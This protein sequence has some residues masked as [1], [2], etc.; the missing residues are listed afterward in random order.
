MT[1]RKIDTFVMVIADQNGGKSNQ[2]R[3][4]FEEPELTAF[5]G[6]Y[7]T[8]RNIT[9]KYYVHPDM[10]LFLR[11]SSWHERQ[12]TYTVVK[13]DLENGYV[14]LRR[15]YKVIVPAQVTKTAKLM[16]GEDLFI[17]I[18]QDFEVRRAFAVWL[19]PDRTGQTPFALS[20]AFASFL[21]GCRHASA[22]A[23]DSLAL[24]PSAA[25]KTNT[26]NARLLAD[27]LFRV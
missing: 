14:D 17:R 3:S 10:D 13:S 24:R 4:L 6:G 2:I 16:S 9:R 19:N 15:R 11:L 18:L 26:V 22:L 5:Y 8:Q 23:I 20:P 27:L 12:E 7:P 21:S 25:P 1:T